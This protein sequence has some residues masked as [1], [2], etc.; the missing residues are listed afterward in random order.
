MTK[1]SNEIEAYGSASPV[2]EIV[3]TYICKEARIHK[4]L[5]E[6][7]MISNPEGQ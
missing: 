2:N 1:P 6:Y 3:S 7:S 4:P 5:L